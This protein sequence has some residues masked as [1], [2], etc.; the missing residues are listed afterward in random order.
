MN[1]RENRKKINNLEKEIF[2][3]KCNEG[4]ELMSE[5]LEKFD[6]KL[7]TERNRS[8]FRHKGRRKTVLKT[9][10]GEVEFSRCVYEHIDEEGNK[11]HIYLLD[12][13]LEFAEYGQMSSVL[14]EK[15]AVNVCEM[16]YR[17]AAAAISEMTGQSISHTAA[18]N[19]I[20]KLG[21]EV[22]KRE[23]NTAKLAKSGKIS[24]EFETK[25]LFEEQDGIW[26][27]MQ[28]HSRK[29]LGKSYEMKLAI[30]YDGTKKTG[31]ERYELTNKVACAGFEG[32][33]KFYA[34]KEGVISSFY[35]TDEIEM[36]ILNGDGAAWIKRSVTDETIHYQLDPYHRNKA[37]ATYVQNEE[38]RE[39]IR[40]LLYKRQ[41]ELCLDVIEAYSN[42]TEDEK[43][44]ENFSTLLTYFTNNKAG[45]ISYK[46]RGLK[47]PPA[48]NNTQYRTCGAMESNIF[49]IIGNRMKG[50]RKCWSENGGNSLAK[51]LCL[52]HTKRLSD[53]LSN[54][55]SIILPD[56]YCE[57]NWEIL[58]AKKV[59]N[60]VGSGYNGW[61]KATVP[62]SCK[63]LKEIAE[64]RPIYEI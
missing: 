54:I 6:K 8:E 7:E 31:K 22:D 4:C 38:A 33:D 21:C 1:I 16:P 28:G 62:Q 14:A 44:K 12:K 39:T 34:R 35:N 30:A 59:P 10:M 43:E 9:I 19:I 52:K 49:T 41:I 27:K 13:T 64:I 60:S 3:I 2:K 5:M 46:D 51:L 20:Q 61:A 32:I 48:K 55:I 53:T 17:Q 36:R 26:L 58:S 63:W 29:K 40:D 57:E 50:H 24:G 18:W 56:N 11:S 47:L 37:I 23:T 42:S 45:L 15:I 25:L